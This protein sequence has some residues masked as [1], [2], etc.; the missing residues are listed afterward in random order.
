[1]SGDPDLAAYG[2]LDIPMSDKAGINFLD[3]M[4]KVRDERIEKLEAAIRKADGFLN[5]GS[6]FND[7]AAPDPIAAHI[8][9]VEALAE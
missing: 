4:V 7:H 1:M 6:A 2:L 5:G 9:L 8:T 3:Q